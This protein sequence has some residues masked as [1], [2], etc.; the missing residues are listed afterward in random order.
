M[1]WFN[2]LI[3]NLI[4]EGIGI[5]VTVFVIDR[6][7]KKYEK[8]KVEL[9]I[10]P[11]KKYL[12]EEF[13]YT[14]WYI[15]RN[16]QRLK[17]LFNDKKLKESES[18]LID[19]IKQINSL[20]DKLNDNLDILNIEERLHFTDERNSMRGLYDSIKYDLK[21]FDESI[22]IKNINFHTKSIIYKAKKCYNSYIE[23]FENKNVVIIDLYEGDLK[24]F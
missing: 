11:L 2:D 6:I 19:I 15:H 10:K 5:I 14:Y 9:E 8:R 17:K 4:T 1:S 13:L 7:L 12:Y 21:N 24:V 23:T 18:L 20:N 16:I 3:P 22:I